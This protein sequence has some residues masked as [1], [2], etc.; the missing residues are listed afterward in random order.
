MVK[1]WALDCAFAPAE[2]NVYRKMGVLSPTPAERQVYGSV[3]LT[4]RPN[5]TIGNMAQVIYGEF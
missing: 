2:C 5:R 4:Y 1:I 3:E